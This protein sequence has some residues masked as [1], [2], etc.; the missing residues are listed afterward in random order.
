LNNSLATIILNK[1]A[2]AVKIKTKQQKAT[3]YMLLKL[4][5]VKNIIANQRQ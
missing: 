1:N 2:N 3:L 4:D 5:D